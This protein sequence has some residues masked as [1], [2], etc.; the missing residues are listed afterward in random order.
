[1]QAG[2]RGCGGARRRGRG[3]SLL[4]GS[5][6]RRCGDGSGLGGGGSPLGS[7]GRHGGGGSTLGG[8]GRNSGSGSSGGFSR[9]GRGRAGHAAAWR[10]RVARHPVIRPGAGG[11]FLPA[12]IGRR[13]FLPGGVGKVLLPGDGLGDVGGGYTSRC[14]V[15][16]H[17][18]S[19]R[20]PRPLFY[21]RLSERYVWFSAPGGA[22]IPRR[23]G[24]AVTRAPCVTP[25]WRYARLVSRLSHPR[26]PA[27]VPSNEPML[28]L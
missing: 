21:R 23:H 7:A 20:P 22:G 15:T 14:H 19:R 9:P 13:L 4:G 25:S 27:A 16:S 11:R 18:R 17:M 12:G 2:G 26:R 5:R 24:P 8:G 10:N 3:G 6:R 1:M 28:K